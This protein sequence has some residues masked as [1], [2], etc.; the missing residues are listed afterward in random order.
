MHTKK[1]PFAIRLIGFS[2]EEGAQV[3]A[4]LAKAPAA[5]PA[6]FCLSEHSLQEPDLYIANGDD[7]LAMTAL[8]AANPTALQPALIVGET[9][10]A[11]PFPQV[12]RPLAPEPILGALAELVAR[13]ADALSLITS[14]G[15]PFVT[16]R[17]RRERLDFDLTDPAVYEGQRR[18]PPNGAV[19]IVDKGGAFRDHVA[20]LLGARKL[21]IEWTDSA[22]TVLRLCEETPVSLVLINTST[23]QIAPYALCAA[24]KALANARRTAVVFLV[25]AAFTYDPARAHAA[26]VRGLL[27]KPIADRHLVAVL[28]KLLS[29]P[30]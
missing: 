21:S 2:S 14:A 13:R 25:S 4:V 8:A 3:E 1:Y 29:L 28:K 9:A 12:A 15:L 16:E 20:K 5:G 23:P 17:R 6:Y 26:G 11:F 27:D 7:L 22:A 24:I 30:A 10:V 18:A 19:L